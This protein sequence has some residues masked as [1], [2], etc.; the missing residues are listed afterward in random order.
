[1]D[2]TQAWLWTD[3]WLTDETEASRQWADGE[4][5]IYDTAEDF[6]ADLP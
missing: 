2:K 5:T 1:M 4:G 3:K 6:L